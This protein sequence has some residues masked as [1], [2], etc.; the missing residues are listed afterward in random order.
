MTINLTKVSWEGEAGED[1]GDNHGL[2]PHIMPRLPGHSD[3]A[4]VAG[5]EAIT[6]EEG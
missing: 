6:V 5:N 2:V 4:S 3:R 1:Q